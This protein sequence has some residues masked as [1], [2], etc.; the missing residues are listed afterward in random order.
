VSTF[1]QWEVAVTDVVKILKARFPNLTTEETLKL[2]H[3]VVKATIAAH[4]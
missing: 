4:G 1:E 3:E 2:A